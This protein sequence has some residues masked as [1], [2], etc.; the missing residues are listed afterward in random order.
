MSRFIRE[1][2]QHDGIDRRG[3]LECMGWAGTGL[4]VSISGGVARSQ[5]IGQDPQPAADLQFVQISDSHIG[6][7]REAN[8]DVTDPRRNGEADQR[9]RA[10]ACVRHSYW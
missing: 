6:F 2:L 8:K 3:F 4:L 10:G 9:A 7:N 5:T 1:N